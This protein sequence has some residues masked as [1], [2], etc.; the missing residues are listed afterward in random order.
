MAPIASA[1]LDYIHVAWGSSHHWA[2]VFKSFM[3]VTSYFNRPIYSLLCRFLYSAWDS[4]A[5]EFD[6][7]NSYIHSNETVS[8]K[9][10]L[11]CSCKLVYKQHNTLTTI[12]VLEH[13]VEHNR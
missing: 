8:L 7:I 2:R 13:N 12:F 6:N 1:C 3:F 10:V 4:V 5:N 11:I 9:L